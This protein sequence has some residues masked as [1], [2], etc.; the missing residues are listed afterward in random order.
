MFESTVLFKGTRPFVI[1][2]NLP[3]RDGKLY[4]DPEIAIDRRVF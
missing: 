2:N 1:K 4:F 3:C